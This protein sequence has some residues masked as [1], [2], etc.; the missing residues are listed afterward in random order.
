MRVS[1]YI[2][3]TKIDLFEDE[4][5]DLK[6]SVQDVNDITKNTTD[7]TKNFKVPAS[8]NNNILFKHYYDA[9]IDN[10]FDARTKVDARLELDGIVFRYGKISLLSVSVKYG[11]PS[12][13]DIV[14]YGNLVNI[15]DKVK[16]D[17]LNVLDL[18]A[19]NHEYNAT[20][21]QQGLTS[22][23]FSDS[24]KYSL[25][26]KKR[27]YYNSD[28]TDNTQT[29]EISNIAFH[30]G[31]VNGVTYKTL[32]PSIKLIR[33]IEAIESYYDIEFS[34]D[35]F[36]RSEF[37]NLYLWLSNTD[38][39]GVGTAYDIIDFDGGDSTYMNLTTNI[40]TYT[41]QY[42]N[43]VNRNFWRLNLTVTPAS[44]FEN[45]TYKVN[46]YVNG[47][48]TIT[49]TFTGAG[50]VTKVLET[51]TDS[52]TW[53]VYFEITADSVFEFTTSLQQDNY[54]YLSSI[55][56]TVSSYTTTGSTQTLTPYVDITNNIPEIKV[57]DFLKGL[58]SAFKLVVI[59]KNPNQPIYVNTLK[60][61]YSEGVVYDLTK[62]IDSS[63]HT[64]ERGNLLNRIVYEFEG[65]TTIL[66]IQF[67]KD[68][69][70]G[71]GDEEAILENE[72]GEPLDGESLEIKLPFEQVIYERLT[73][74]DDNSQTNIQ[75]GAIIDEDLSRTT[76]KPH[77]HYI[78]SVNLGS[79]TISFIDE[80][81]T[82][83]ELD[84]VNVPSHTLGFENPQH[85]FIF[86]AEFSTYTTELILNTLYKNWHFDF[87]TSIFNIKRRT[88]KF[89]AYNL[90]YRYLMS[91][92]LNDVIQIKD[93][94]YRIN[95][96][97]TNLITGKVSFEL[98]NSF[99]NTLNYFDTSQTLII[100]SQR[101]SQETVY[102][103]ELGNKDY[104]L[105]DEGYG[106]SWITLSES[107][108]L[109]VLDID[110]NNTGAERYASITIQNTEKTKTKTVIVRQLNGNV[111]WDSEEI[112]FDSETTTFDSL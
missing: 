111:T 65:P 83:Y 9:T 107:G 71:Y 59:Q 17:N 105:I 44:G 8:S 99:D 50:T 90:P 112:T 76:I 98:I 57:I 29:P 69:G 15:K 51:Q 56:S 49:D 33:I 25:I 89:T 85:S 103:N 41:S 62:Y 86:S 102:V 110:D 94:F 70:L 34:R 28:N 21:V 72:D 77:I 96:F 82:Q 46:H 87:I 80:T 18:T 5:I 53:D 40:G 6:S 27:Y 75:Y 64:V 1:L 78:N 108:N 54:I 47:Q 4:T 66:N 92:D 7:F 10:T 20:N 48:K 61:Y 43:V 23:L 74:I 19:F 101:A 11:K 91:L 104:T 2:Q 52:Q 24:I 26:S 22:G 42:T 37:D 45:I 13:Y 35:F 16:E 73:D 97:N 31:G 88:F 60:D 12:A 58:F 79:K 84:T 109:L 100:A 55:Y 38:E 39:F 93:N 3:N 106:T 36:G 14:F 95:S 30:T 63:S 81:S 67:S 32:N 68:S